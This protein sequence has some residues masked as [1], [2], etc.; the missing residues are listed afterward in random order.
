VVPITPPATACREQGT[1][2][3]STHVSPI[4]SAESL[5]RTTTALR[6]LHNNNNGGG[7]RPEQQEQPAAAR[8][9][10]EV[11]STAGVAGGGLR[12]GCE[13]RRRRR[14]TQHSTLA[15]GCQAAAARVASAPLFSRAACRGAPHAAHWSL[16][17]AARSA[18]LEHWTIFYV[19]TNSAAL[20]R[21]AAVLDALACTALVAAAVGAARACAAAVLARPGRACARARGRRSSSRRSLPSRQ[22]A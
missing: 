19:W 18:E 2:R 14:R 7:G 17:L 10:P 22:N 5:T 13:S 12:S 21:P 20:A 8:A 3:R 4:S 16:E 1:S 6:C 11:C 9:Q 15:A